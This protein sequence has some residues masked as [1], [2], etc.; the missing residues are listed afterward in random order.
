MAPKEKNERREYKAI[1]M[2]LHGQLPLSEQEK[3][4]LPLKENE[5]LI[6]VSTNVAESS[7]TV[8]DVKFIIDACR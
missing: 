1:V 6:L 3:I 4:Y 5:R 8:P 7:L 2:Q